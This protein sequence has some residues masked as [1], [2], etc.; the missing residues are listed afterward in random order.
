MPFWWVHDFIFAAPVSPGQRDAPRGSHASPDSNIL[1]MPIRP[2]QWELLKK[3]P[4]NSFPWSVRAVHAMENAQCRNLADVFSIPKADWTKRRYVGKKCV[5]EMAKQIQSF[6][7]IRRIITFRPPCDTT[8]IEQNLRNGQIRAALAGAF[9]MGGLTPN[10]IRV[11]EMRYGIA[12]QQP[13]TQTEC[14]RSL[15]RSRQRMRQLELGGM[16]RLSRHP[17]ILRAF[18]NELQAIQGRLMR[19]M[20]GENNSFIPKK[21][22]MRELN[23]KVGGPEGLL[24]KVCYG[25]LRKWLDKNLTS[26]P[27]GWRIPA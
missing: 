11:L 8:A 25:N 19:Q 18:Q 24:L 1:Q 10:E 2:A 27:K 3:T 13:L 26:T 22:T 15:H 6:L 12:G 23:K 7:K 5:T 21:I 20:A 17:D 16:G 4:V 14:A 9:A